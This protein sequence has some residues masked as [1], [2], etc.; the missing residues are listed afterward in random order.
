MTALDRAGRVVIV[1]TGVAGATAAQGLRGG[2][3]TGTITLVGDEAEA[4]YRRPVLSKDLLAGKTDIVRAGLKPVAY[5]AEQHIDLRVGETV[6]DI[7]PSA[8]TVALGDGGV[9]GYDALVLAT[10]G[11]PRMLPGVSSPRVHHLRRHADV[12]ALR[13][14]LREGS[15]L[16][17]IGGGLIGSEVASTARELGCAVTVLEAAD[18]PLARLVPAPVGAALAGL[19]REAGVDLHT[20]VALA[21]V[22]AGPDTVTAIAV[23]GRR[24]RADA[25]VVAIG[26]VPNTELGARAGA[27]IDNGIVVDELLRTTVDGVFAIGDVA[28]VPN[29]VLGGRYRGEHWNT[30][31][32]HGTAVARSLLGAGSPFDVV[33]WAW[34]NQFGRGIQVAGWPEADDELLVRGS[35]D[36]RDFTALCRR[37][38]RIVGAITM[39]RPK[40]TR[41]ARMLIG[42]GGVVAA[43]A[44]L[45]PHTDLAA[46][47]S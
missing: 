22:E 34:S 42:R 2:G 33:P 8:R 41:T 37:D 19:H 29:T 45:D 43:E 10:G 36:E 38:G 40:D 3:F 14:R 17:V 15:S 12:P 30:A 13:G 23:D 27:A 20:G 7:D 11:R 1:G 47:A 6:I 4:P 26:T 46:L 24:W 44:L 31:Q 5:W 28:S 21:G 35:I 18:R 25:A 32:D 9:L 39:G 16:L